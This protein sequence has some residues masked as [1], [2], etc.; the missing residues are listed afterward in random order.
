MKKMMIILAILFCSTV[1]AFESKL[2]LI[3][4]ESTK[5]YVNN[6]LFEPQANGSYV[7]W[8]GKAKDLVIR[9]DKVGYISKTVVYRY[10][11]EKKKDDNF[12]YYLRGINYF[13]IDLEK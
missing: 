8:L 1:K 5:V 13:I 3:V 10:S 12:V 11:R 6:K 7:I 9:Y 4:P 2:V